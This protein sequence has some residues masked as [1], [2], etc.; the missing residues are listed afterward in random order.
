[1][2]CTI[3]DAVSMF[4][5]HI[6][7]TGDILIKHYGIVRTAESRITLL[8]VPNFLRQ[9]YIHKL[10][11]RGSLGFRTMVKVDTLILEYVLSGPKYNK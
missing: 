10:R 7:L 11:Y 9:P 2:V 5:G 6:F 3:L 4:A 8:R 1:M